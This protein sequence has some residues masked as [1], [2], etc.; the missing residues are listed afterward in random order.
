MK[1]I[2]SSVV[3]QTKKICS[4]ISFQTVVENIV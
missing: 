1:M 4:I 2:A 3:L